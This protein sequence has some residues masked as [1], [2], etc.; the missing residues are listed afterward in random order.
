LYF[1]STGCGVTSVF[2]R[3]SEWQRGA[4]RPPVT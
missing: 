3:L 2:R 4:V 1:G